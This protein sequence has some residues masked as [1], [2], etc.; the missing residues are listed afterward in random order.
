[1]LKKII[2]LALC[3]AFLMGCFAAC[4]N[5][6]GLKNGRL[7][8]VTTIFPVYDWCREILGGEADGVELVMLLDSGVDLHS[9]QPTAADLIRISDCDVFAFVGGE[10][11]GWT[12]DALKGDANPDRKTVN[13]LEA[14]GDMVREEETVEGMEAEAEEEDG[15]EEPEADEHVWLSLKNAAV[16]VDA[17]TDAICAADPDRADAYRANAASYREKLAALDERY[18]EAAQAGSKKTLL[19][20]DRFPF[21]YLV[22]DYGLSY[23]AAF[24]GCSAESEASFRTIVF[25]AEKT[26]ELQLGAICQIE[27]ADGS[28]ARTIRDNTAGKDQKIL[29]FDSLQ[30][31]TAK[32]AEEGITYLSVMENNLEVLKEALQ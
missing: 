7:T 16:L 2:V 6:E 12:E 32:R 19:F 13:L 26:D 25:L 15:E 28:I 21:R 30:S 8:I 31:V 29:T 17:L 24:S 14:L 1:M 3:L 23:Y 9:Y 5:G 18:A 27:S 11:D 22:E 4:G 10:S 20:G